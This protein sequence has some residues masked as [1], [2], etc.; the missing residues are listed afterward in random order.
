MVLSPFNYYIVAYTLAVLNAKNLNKVIP[1]FFHKKY[2]ILR[3]VNAW[4]RDK[5]NLP[6][7]LQ[8][9]NNPNSGAR[10][11]ID[12]SALIG[13]ATPNGIAGFQKKVGGN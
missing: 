5:W 11:C 10:L 12:W 3:L 8:E 2:F 13:A 9:L 4:R 7:K 6:F 1:V